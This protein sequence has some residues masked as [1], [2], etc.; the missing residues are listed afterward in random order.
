MSGAAP[1]ALLDD[2]AASAARPT[3]RLYA[4]YVCTLRSD[5]PAQIDV[6]WAEVADA[7]RRGLEVVVLADY[8]WGVR[9]AGQPGRVGA[10]GALRVLLFKSCT[11]LDAAAVEAWLAQAD[12]DAADAQPSA[13]AVRGVE[14]EVNALAFAGAVDRIHAAIRGGETYQA[15]LTFG[16]SAE[17]AGAPVALYRR[18]RARQPVPFGALIA[19]PPGDM[20]GVTHVLSLSPELFVRGEQGTLTAR[21]MKGTAPR[22]ADIASDLLAREQLANAK[23]RAENLMIVDLLRNDLG[24]IATTG[25]VRVPALFDIEAHPTL[26][27]MT[28]TITATLAPRRGFA[29]VLRALF[30]CGSVTGA[31]KHRTLAILQALER[32]PRGS[33]CGAIGWVDAPAADAACGDFCLSVPIRTMTL[34]PPRDGWRPARLPVGAGITLD[35][36][37]ADEYAECLLKARFLTGM[38]TG[39]ALIET[40]RA[41]NGSVPLLHRHL[42]RLVTSAHAF[43]IACDVARIAA[44]V[45]AAA[46]ASV[47]GGPQ[48][49]RLLVPAHGEPG[50]Q[51]DRLEAL[52]AGTVRVAW[53]TTPVDADAWPLAHKTTLRGHYDRALRD[54]QARGLFD[55]LHVNHHGEVTEG[56]RSNV[57]VRLDG[58]WLT[59]PL[60]C[61]VLPGAMRAELLSDPC[62]NAREAILRPADVA[63]AE[64]VVFCNALRGTLRAS[65]DGFDGLPRKQ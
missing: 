13:V 19:L 27:Q 15:N 22:H 30:P 65:V 56:A 17:I 36:V 24:R 50:L 40:M 57:F 31:P 10:P 25:S 51:V 34:A 23:N 26:W 46:R 35:S 2:A 38:P 60:S 9:L 7:Q 55:L 52:P 59:P 53:S 48:R 49:L 37:A 47:E 18:L 5:D 6:F 21:P 12:T 8:E 42:A 58:Q 20:D 14:A 1:F 45:E 63:R 61:G 11:R 4:D 28:S 29:D 43:G 33:Y 64:C 41:E 44:R 3:S 54:A 32:S 16:L 39:L 62:W